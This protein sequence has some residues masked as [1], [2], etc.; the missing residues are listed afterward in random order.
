M[1]ELALGFGACLNGDLFPLL[2]RFL[3]LVRFAMLVVYV[4]VCLL[5]TILDLDFSYKEYV[6]LVLVN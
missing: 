3:P 2:P 6:S 4:N 5:K 1:S